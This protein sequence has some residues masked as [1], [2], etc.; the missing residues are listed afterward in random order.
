VKKRIEEN[1]GDCTIRILPTADGYRGA[2]IC[3]GKATEPLDDSDPDRLYARLRNQAGTLHPNYF[4]MDGAVA[5][6]L[7]FFPGGFSDPLYV[8]DERS[9][10]LR[11]HE[12][13]KATLPLES[14]LDVTAEQ[15]A[16]VRHAFVTNLLSPY[17]LARASAVLRGATG[18]D[19]VRGAAMFA[20]GNYGAGL[21]AMSKAVERQGRISWPIATYL[22]NLWTPTEHMFLKPV[23]TCDFAQRI[24][25]EFQHEYD[26]AMEPSVYLALLRLVADTE[27]GLAGLK[28]QDRI[29]VQSF[30]WVVGDYGEAEADNLKRRRAKL[31]G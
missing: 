25:H 19:Y 8:A 24:G 10:K 30:I 14:A 22:P 1:I 4:G 26:P 6:F 31:A 7:S 5:R 16:E 9:Y 29:D 12:T 13:L 23:A 20:L 18:K 21:A 11:S 17:E 3:K 28:P 15:A 27:A 2:V